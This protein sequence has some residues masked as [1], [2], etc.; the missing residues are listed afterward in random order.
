MSVPRRY[1]NTVSC[2]TVIESVNGRVLSWRDCAKSPATFEPYLRFVGIITV[3]KV[4]DYD[5]P[6]SFILEYIKRMEWKAADS[7]ASSDTLKEPYSNDWVCQALLHLC[8]RRTIGLPLNVKNDLD[9]HIT[10][11]LIKLLRNDAS[12]FNLYPIISLVEDEETV[13]GRTKF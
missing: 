7:L 4:V 2:G 3:A 11:G 8:D 9:G 6:P 5:P 1:D 13:F 12:K 10:E